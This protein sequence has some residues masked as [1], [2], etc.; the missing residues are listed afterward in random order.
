M[1]DLR[2]TVLEA[3]VAADRNGGEVHQAYVRAVEQQGTSRDEKHKI[4]HWLDSERLVDADTLPSGRSGEFSEFR[5]HGVTSKA[6][7]LHD[8]QRSVSPTPLGQGAA[9]LLRRMFE[10]HESFLGSERGFVVSES[11]RDVTLIFAGMNDNIVD[12][13]T[14]AL[15]ELE[16]R[17]FIM[18]G[19]ANVRF[20]TDAG[21]EAA[22]RIAPIRFTRARLTTTP[23]TLNLRNT[24]LG[25]AGSFGVHLRDV[26]R[27]QHTELEW[28]SNDNQTVDLVIGLT[29][30]LSNDASDVPMSLPEFSAAIEL[31]PNETAI[32]AVGLY[33]PR[34]DRGDVARFSPDQENT[35]AVR[36]IAGWILYDSD[37]ESSPRRRDMLNLDQTAD[38]AAALEGMTGALQRHAQD[39]ETPEVDS[40]LIQAKLR[41]IR[42][43]QQD[44]QADPQI[45][46]LIIRSLVRNFADAMQP[47]QTIADS[48]VEEGFDPD[49]AATIGNRLDEA[50]ALIASDDFGH[51]DP[52]TS[53]Q[54]LAQAAELVDEAEEQIGTG[55]PTPQREGDGSS[56]D[57]A[58]EVKKSFIKVVAEGGLKS[59]WSYLIGSNLI[60]AGVS[61]LGRL[62]DLVR[63]LT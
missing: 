38:A 54:T 3:L 17:G 50:I 51:N 32:T 63:T 55:E 9:F 4:E 6:R 31:R 10:L 61:L 24:V 7:N 43:W 37:P 16:H 21:M 48:L 58:D 44:P 40:D 28:S 15:A 2:R 8:D 25:G 1:E 46:E 41:Q 20:L 30:Q 56:I 47:G 62:W 59:A 39:P 34:P 35:M 45:L 60:Q 22:R 18:K 29:T 11:L 26:L 13:D 27:S 57:V 42:A 12:V 23:E 49:I 19:D 36:L 5:I 53:A 52:E 14:Q 33:S